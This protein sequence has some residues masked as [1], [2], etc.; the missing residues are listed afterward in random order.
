MLKVVMPPLKNVNFCWFRQR[1]K[2]NSVGVILRRACAK[3]GNEKKQRLEYTGWW[4][5]VNCV[6]EG[7]GWG[8]GWGIGGR[9]KLQRSHSI[10]PHLHFHIYMLFL[11]CCFLIFKVVGSNALNWRKTTLNNFLLVRQKIKLKALTFLTEAN[12]SWY[13][14]R[15]GTI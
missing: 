8:W 1:A 2:T 13:S 10:S 7:W 12:R 5:R 6:W 3:R 4:I 14:E 9:K 15:N 11:A